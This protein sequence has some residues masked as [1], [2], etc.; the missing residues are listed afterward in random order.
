MKLITQTFAMVFLSLSALCVIAEPQMNTVELFAKKNE[1]VD[2]KLSPS[3][4]YIGIRRIQDDVSRLVVVDVKS[5][6]VVS[7]IE[8]RGREQVGAFQWAN[9]ERIIIKILSNKEQ[10]G[11]FVFYGELYSFDITKNKGNMIFGSRMRS[12]RTDNTREKLILEKHKAMASSW[13][14]IISMFP[15]DKEHIL[16]AARPYSGKQNKI[17]RIYLLNVNNGNISFYTEAPAAHVRYVTDQ[18]GDIAF[19]TTFDKEND[20]VAFEFLR[21]TKS[22]NVVKD[23]SYTDWFK[24]LLYDSKKRKLTFLDSY[25]KDKRTLFTLDVANNKVSP[26]FEDADREIYWVHLNE[27]T[28]KVLGVEI[29]NGYPEYHLVKSLKDGGEIFRELVQV[30]KGYEISDVSSNMDETLYSVRASN[31]VEPGAWYLYDI[32]SKKVQ[33]I[34]KKFE[35]LDRARLS[36]TQA[37][38]FKSRDDENV[39]GHLTIPLNNKKEKYPAILLARKN[40]TGQS[41]WSY[42]HTR[43][44][45]SS[46]GY[47]VIEINNRGSTVYGRRFADLADL[48]LGDNVQYD[49]IDGVNYLIEQGIIDKEKICTMGEFVGGYSAVQLSVLENK[50]FKCA[51]AKSAFYELS[52]FKKEWMDSELVWRESRFKEIFGDSSALLAKFSP[53]NY[54]KKLKSPLLV[55]HGENDRQVPIEQAENL[56][57]RLKKLGKEHV[58]L[59]LENEREHVFKE[60]SRREYMKAIKLFLQKHNPAFE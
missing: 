33:F 17:P 11:G 14:Q 45:L 31:D 47:A 60:E 50:L 49:L 44:F 8:F 13:A 12:I 5:K 16:I 2:V 28:S 15:S 48:H 56:V 23:F 59:E 34:A 20:K 53:I 7:H 18:Y 29:D 27:R 58:W 25:D 51:V 9:D 4:K 46:L 24:P 30:F 26:I 35:H 3:G 19:A 54:L 21:E 36:R 6:E 40:L 32:K 41:V 42:G 38:S 22:W 39:S 43:Q 55:I 57:R 1:V 37:F 10:F 52:L